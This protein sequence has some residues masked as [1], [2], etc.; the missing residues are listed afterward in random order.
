MCAWDRLTCLDDG[1]RE[2]IRVKVVA[3]RN[4]AKS[5]LP[6]CSR[7]PVGARTQ[8]SIQRGSPWIDDVNRQ[9]RHQLDCACNFP[10]RE[11][12]RSS[13]K[14]PR[15]SGSRN[16]PNIAERQSVGSIKIG[17]STVC[18]SIQVVS[19]GIGGVQTSTPVWL[20]I[21]IGTSSWIRG[22]V[23]RLRKR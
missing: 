10:V 2:G 13:G 1:S 3:C 18:S 7:C 4:I 15:E 12:V 16:V 23:D 20:P 5:R 21:Q 6:P 19:P 22:V 17:K 8:Q 14:F 9:T 11:Q